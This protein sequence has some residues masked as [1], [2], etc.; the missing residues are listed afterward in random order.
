LGRDLV[1]LAQRR[2]DGERKTGRNETGDVP[3][4]PADMLEIGDYPFADLAPD[5]RDQERSAR[6]DVDRLAGIFPSVSQHIPAEQ[7]HRHSL[8]PPQLDR[9]VGGP[10]RGREVVHILVRGDLRPSAQRTLGPLT[11]A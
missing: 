4:D 8:V 10:W 5:G 2:L 6:R 11:I 7:R 1:A 3:L 9:S